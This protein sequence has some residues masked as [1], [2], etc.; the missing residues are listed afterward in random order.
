[1]Y[2]IG[3]NSISK[4]WPLWFSDFWMCLAIVLSF[5]MLLEVINAAVK[6]WGTC[7]PSLRCFLKLRSTQFLLEPQISNYWDFLSAFWGESLH[8]R[9]LRRWYEEAAEPV[10]RSRASL[11]L[12]RGPECTLYCT[13]GLLLPLLW[14]AQMSDARR[15]QSGRGVLFIFLFLTPSHGS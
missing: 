1:M 2:D 8:W 12:E 14:A 11:E 6:R 13:L 3:C 4:Q 15:T 9:A 5:P 10:N 7:F